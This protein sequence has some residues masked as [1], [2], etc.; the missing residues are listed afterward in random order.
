MR[1]RTKALMAASLLSVA[2]GVA[3]AST[4]ILSFNI[5]NNTSQAWDS[6]LFEI[7]APLASPFNPAALALVL[8]DTQ[9]AA[10]HTT[11]NINAS[12]LVNESAKQVRFSFNELGRVQPGQTYSYTVTVNNPEDSAFRI[13]RIATPIPTPGTA[14]LAGVA[15][16]VAVRR[17]RSA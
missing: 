1:L 13:V 17:R 8:F 15:G 10:A 5:T 7:R 2:G 6:L 12:A 4:S 14:A 11:T 9:S 16:L 3:S